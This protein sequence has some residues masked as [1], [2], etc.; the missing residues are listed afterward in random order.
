MSYS[1]SPGTALSNP[2]IAGPIANPTITTT[3]TV[4]VTNSFGCTASDSLIITVKPAPPVSAG[5]DSA[6]CI[7]ESVHLNATSTGSGTYSMEPVG[8]LKC[9]KYSQSY[10]YARHNDNIYCWNTVLFKRMLSTDNVVVTVNPIPTILL[11]ILPIG[12]AYVGEIVSITATPTPP[13]VNAEYYFYV[14][15]V[16]VESGTNNVYQTNTLLN[17]QIVT[18]TVLESGCLSRSSMVLSF[19]NIKPIP[20]AFIT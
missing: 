18:A 6:V 2:N 3:Y 12:I 17:G 4:T 19:P 9:D 16:L 14:N 8:R 1:W 15:G 7:G 11:S 13:D 20:N 5:A 10:S